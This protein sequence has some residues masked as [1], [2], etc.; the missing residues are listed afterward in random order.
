MPE[1]LE[2]P[3]AT[4]LEDETVSEETAE[5]MIDRVPEKAVEKASNTIHNYDKDH[6]ILSK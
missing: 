4:K 2:N 6:A 1:Q 3:G 5:K